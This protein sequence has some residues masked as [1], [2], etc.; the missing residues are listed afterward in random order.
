MTTLH[1]WFQWLNVSY[2]ALQ[3]FD[4][5]CVPKSVLWLNLRA[6]LI[7]ELAN[8]F[9]MEGFSLQ[10]LDVGQNRLMRLDRGSLQETLRVV[11]TRLL[12][13][14]ISLSIVL[15]FRTAQK[16]SKSLRIFGI[17][18]GNE[19]ND[20]LGDHEIFQR[21]FKS[22]PHLFNQYHQVTLGILLFQFLSIIQ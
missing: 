19:D 11:R 20:S 7:E 2:N 22:F 6:N 16:L 12:S 10:T 5:A 4:Y 3:W 9:K 14:P 18:H 15:P 21:P 1:H 8:Y 17:K 13:I